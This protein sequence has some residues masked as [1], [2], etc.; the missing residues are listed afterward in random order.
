M[1]VALILLGYAAALAY[2]GPRLMSR[3]GWTDRAPRLGIAG[4]Q[5]LTFTVVVS[6]TLAGLALV[7]PSVR[8][9]SGLADVLRTCVMA[10]RAQYAT[11]GGAAVGA[12]G[13]VLAVAV[14]GRCGWC[15]TSALRQAARCR[16]RQREV[17]AVT[18]QSHPDLGAVVLC[19]AKPAVYCLPGRGRNIVVTAGALE[20]LD[21]RQ[22]A[23]AL[24]HE[25]AHLDQRH[26]LVIAFATGIAW[27]FS[28]VPL[29]TRGLSETRRLVELLADDV[30]VQSTDRLTLA[31]ALLTLA[32][33]PTPVA[34][35]GVGGASAARVRR[36]VG[37]DHPLDRRRRAGTFV[38]VLGL[39][40]APM[41]ALATPAVAATQMNYCATQVV[42]A[43]SV[44]PR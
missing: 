11:P 35:L 22:L 29:F 19:E 6:V 23:A 2:V 16:S 5:S 38:G 40:V 14:A 24:A 17:L 18:G 21:D 1:I 4:W 15:V 36:L 3:G 31:E 42:A 26:D 32:G 28:R 7:V 8:V 27:A 41:I 10:L 13:A 44:S 34:A 20:L 43:S 9:S 25:R 39:L 33:A 12:T 30:A 37:P